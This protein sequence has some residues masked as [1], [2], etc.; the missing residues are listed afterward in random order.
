MP[1]ISTCRVCKNNMNQDCVEVCAPARD[2]SRFELR[3]G[4]RLED[5]PRFPLAQLDDMKSIA[6]GRVISLYTSLMFD[7][8][9]GYDN[10]Y[11]N[12]YSRS[13]QISEAVTLE[14]LLAR[15]PEENPL[16]PDW[17]KREDPPVRLRD[18]VA[19]EAQRLERNQPPD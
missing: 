17:K 10:G 12:D 18:L 1:P 6:R 13:R 11:D 7:H 19:R 8:M 9:M 5:L 4:T 3:K 15:H 2:Y 14:S 16:H